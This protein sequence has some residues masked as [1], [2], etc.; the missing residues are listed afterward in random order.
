MFWGVTLDSGNRYTQTV[1][2]SF[3]LSMAALGFQN[4][5][6]VPVTVMVEVDK[7]QFVL[8]TLQPGKIPQQ[9]LDYCFTEG[10]EIT[11]FTEG[12]GDVHLTGYLM[13]EP[14]TLEF[15]ES[16]EEVSNS[17]SAEEDDESSS[18]EV[19]LGDLFQSG[20]LI[21]DGSDD[22][23]EESGDVDWDP[24]KD[25]PKKKKTSKKKKKKKQAENLDGNNIIS[26]MDVEQAEVTMSNDGTSGE[27]EDST[28][29]QNS[30]QSENELRKK[31][32]NKKKRKTS[33][34]ENQTIENGFKSAKKLKKKAKKT[35]LNS[36]NS[37][38]KIEKTKTQ[39]NSSGQTSLDTSSP[40]KNIDTQVKQETQMNKEKVTQPSSG[41]QNDQAQATP[42][43]ISQG[44]S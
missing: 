3:H 31:D 4:F 39:E 5:S 24:L 20:D 12:P 13:E 9:P 33:E 25:N 8:C 2:K 28:G 7:A 15:E 42:V 26:L 18:E 16:A 36:P 40:T 43:S 6:S 44:C 22:E 35:Q 19:T 37:D 34:T 10:E 41:K 38:G 23:D 30:T 17:D 27:N 11:F 1:E 32:G 21:G 14:S 29:G